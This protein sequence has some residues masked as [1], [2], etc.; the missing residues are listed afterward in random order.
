MIFLVGPRQAGKTT[1]SL[2]AKEFT[3]QFGYL[4]WD[5]VDHRKVILEGVRG[6]ANFSGLDRLSS[7]TPIIVFDEIHKYGKWKDFLKG[8]FDEYKG[9]VHIIVTGSSR[10]D[11]YKKEG[12][13]LMGRYFHYRLHQL[14][15]SELGR[16]DLSDKETRDPFQTKGE[17]F[18]KLLKNGGFPEPFLKDNPR[19]LNRWKTFPLIPFAAG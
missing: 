2:M 9:K 14:S 6:V 15:L 3:D 12:D 1:V 11:V 8:F 7:R 17:D 10:L 13:S 5:N 4:N 18:D 16:I 19:F